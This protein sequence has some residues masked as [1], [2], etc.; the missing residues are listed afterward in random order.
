VHLIGGAAA[1]EFFYRGVLLSALIPIMGIWSVIAVAACFVGEHLVHFNAEEQFDG[2]DFTVH[3][4]LSLG[5]G[6]VVYFSNT[7][8]AA[9]VGHV[10][11]NA[12]AVYLNLRRGLLRSKTIRHSA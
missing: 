2:R 8:F 6:V 1:Q 7:L 9:V 3:A 10:L 5:L 12:P 4:V 11:Y